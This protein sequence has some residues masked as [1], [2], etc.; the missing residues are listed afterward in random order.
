VI[1]VAPDGVATAHAL[2][3]WALERGLD[4]RGFSVAKPTLED[5]YLQLTADTHEE[6]LR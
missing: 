5:I 1:V 3:G 2:T 6:V 4:L